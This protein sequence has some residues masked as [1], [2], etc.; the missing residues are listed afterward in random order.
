[1]TA[2]RLTTQKRTPRTPQELARRRLLLDA[3]SG[4]LGYGGPITTP[5]P[6]RDG[7]SDHDR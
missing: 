4:A 2:T 6:Y 7:R 3:A 5:T 1:M